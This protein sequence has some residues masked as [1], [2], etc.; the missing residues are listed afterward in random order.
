LAVAVLWIR[1]PH[2]GAARPLRVGRSTVRTPAMHVPSRDCSKQKGKGGNF[3]D[4]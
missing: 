3:K 4:K 1:R 2:K